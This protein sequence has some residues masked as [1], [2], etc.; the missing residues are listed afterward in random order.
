M[1]QTDT[2]DNPLANMA[3]EIDREHFKCEGCLEQKAVSEMVVTRHPVRQ[4]A[5]PPLCSD[6]SASMCTALSRLCAPKPDALDEAIT[7]LNEMLAL[8]PDAMLA[9]VEHRVPCSTA[10]IAHP[11]CQVTGTI[12]SVGMLGVINGL[13]GVDAKGWGFVVAHFEEDGRLFKFSRRAPG[14]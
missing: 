11:T 12:P 5:F 4:F 2:I 10:L 3:Q 6:C 13:F 1:S 14:A 9:L 8:D 7:R